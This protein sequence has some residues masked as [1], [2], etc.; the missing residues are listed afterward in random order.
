MPNGP[1]VYPRGGLGVSSPSALAGILP[2]LFWRGVAAWRRSLIGLESGVEDLQLGVVRF[3]LAVSGFQ[4][5]D[6]GDAGQIHA[7]V[8]KFGDPRKALE[9]VVAVAASA[10]I[11]AR[12][13]E[14][15]PALIEPQRLWPN[16]GQLR[17]HRD[18]VDA[19]RGS[20]L[21]VVGQPLLL[22]KFSFTATCVSIHSVVSQSYVRR[23]RSS[24]L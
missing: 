15:S 2:P 22:E 10:S 5:Q 14:Q 1:G 6:V 3:Q 9:V 19:A 12:R 17:G 8:D 13:G 11:G 24:A 7:L 4:I 21:R 18:A 16:A 20:G 23:H